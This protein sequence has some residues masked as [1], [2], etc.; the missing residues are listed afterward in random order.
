[1]HSKKSLLC[2]FL[3]TPNSS[4]STT[5]LYLHRYTDKKGLKHYSGEN[6]IYHYRTSCKNHY[7]RN[8][9]LE[10]RVCFCAVQDK[11]LE[12]STLAC[13]DCFFTSFHFSL[14]FI[15]TKRD[16]TYWYLP[17]IRDVKRKQGFPER[18]EVTKTLNW[19]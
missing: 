9:S 4:L 12:N 19:K 7:I 11:A 3:C 18:H 16:T 15:S 6:I 1:M 17:Y 5:Y 8:E 2:S 10:I 13:T 14:R